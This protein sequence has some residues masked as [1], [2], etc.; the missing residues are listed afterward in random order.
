ML[1]DAHLDLAFS[2]IG[3]GRDLRLP[4]AELRHKERRR[5]P[6]PAG[7]AT[8]S[9]P[10]LREGGIG[11]VCATLFTLPERYA[12]GMGASEAVTYKDQQS[13]YRAA[14]QQLDYYKRLA[15]EVDYIRLVT[16]LATLEEVIASHQ[17]TEDETEPARLLGLIPLMEGADPI[18]APEE[19]EEWYERGLR[20]IGPAWSNTRYAAGAWDGREGFSKDGF[21]LME[22]MADLGFI[23]DITHLSEK[24]SFEALERYGGTIVAT[25]CNARALVPGERQLSDSQL[26]ALAERGGVCGIVLNNS[27]LRK[28]HRPGE[29]RE[30]VTLEHIV[31]HI[32]HICQ[33]TGSADHAGL[34]SD[35]DGGFGLLD[36]PH[37]LDSAADLPQI[38]TALTERGYDPTHI[39]QIMSGNWLRTLRHT[40]PG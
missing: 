14:G 18:R 25:H 6:N 12:S 20:L 3:Y 32:D 1:F 10:A 4:V 30:R 38:A 13:A 33:I 24:A 16:D 29:R 17:P 11:L 9:L 36:I 15:D 8:T 37:G 5:R 2:A 28:G 23:L 35:L 27:F 34:G 40:W 19:L 22:I 31:A 7:I 21:A 39:D 26:R